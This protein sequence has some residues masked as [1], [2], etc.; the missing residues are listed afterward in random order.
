MEERK[1]YKAVK[2]ENGDYE[3][4]IDA[5]DSTLK[6]MSEMEARMK[7]NQMQGTLTSEQFAHR[8]L[9]NAKILGPEIDVVYWNGEGINV[10]GLRVLG[11][12][13][14]RILKSHPTFGVYT[15]IFDG[16][17]IIWCIQQN[18]DAPGVMT[19]ACTNGRYMA[20]DLLFFQKLMETATKIGR[21]N[22]LKNNTDIPTA[23]REARYVYA[24]F[25]MLHECMH[26]FF[27]HNMRALIKGVPADTHHFNISN[28]AMDA[29]INGL[30][31]V[32][33]PIYA[34][35]TENS[36]GGIFDKDAI[37][38]RWEETYDR[39]L[40]SM[41]PQAQ[42]ILV[43][44]SGQG[45]SSDKKGGQQDNQKGQQ[46]DGQSDNGNG[47][48]GQQGQQGQEGQS[49]NSNQGQ[50]QQGDGQQ[51]QGQGQSGNSQG[52]SGQGQEG[53][54]GSSG[55]NSGNGND[56]ASQ[57]QSGQPSRGKGG[58]PATGEEGYNPDM[59]E[60]ETYKN[61]KGQTCTNI[62]S[63]EG[64]QNGEITLL[65]DVVGN[66]TMAEV[67][68]QAGKPIPEDAL[69]ASG[70]ADKMYEKHKDQLRKTKIKQNNGGKGACNLMEYVWTLF[71]VE[72]PLIDWRSALK[73]FMNMRDERKDFNRK[74]SRVITNP[75]LYP[76]DVMPRRRE[77]L[78]KSKIT[79][80]FYLIDSSG[81]MNLDCIA[82]GLM[83]EVLGIEDMCGVMN[84]GLAY[85]SDGISPKEGAVRIWKRDSKGAKLSDSEKSKILKKIIPDKGI[86]YVNGGTDLEKALKQ[87][88]AMED[89]FKPGRTRLIIISDADGGTE[90]TESIVANIKN[91][92]N[93]VFFLVI[94][95]EKV[96][97]EYIRKAM[98]TLDIDDSCLTGV[99]Y[100]EV[101]ENSKNIKLNED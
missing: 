11:E 87:L 85:F 31:E 12:N 71:H 21:E 98:M 32:N 18:R 6:P 67:A 63:G 34:K 19:T 37:A 89:I 47:Q 64:Q 72:E 33:Y 93:K 50:G 88:I 46:G 76:L 69:D 1:K 26:A 96:L 74:T 54:S 45:Q 83:S 29:E 22:A 79:D 57:G 58:G 52:Q 55:S 66:D 43:K 10:A 82:A 90:L 48:D 51:G 53:Q 101:Q 68:E 86:D 49:G 60:G 2:N 92:V 56:N 16:T 42:K 65:A 99:S 28:I 38:V 77:D 40:K 5:P 14:W 13:Y 4:N 9:G 94:N 78:N 20:I 41:P 44:M 36:G 61:D 73:R 97:N 62:N 15:R 8:H 81:S 25:I 80:V 35:V 84:S 59:A 100:E 39:Y 24:T 91:S 70:I 17:N 23:E 75:K 7:V 30:I 95:N 27:K 3:I